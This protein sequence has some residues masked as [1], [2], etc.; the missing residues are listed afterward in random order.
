MELSGSAAA[1]EGL[2]ARLSHSLGLF[3]AA[4]CI[5]KLHAY[6]EGGRRAEGGS[7]QV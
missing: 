3:P 6:K 1:A 5:K 7:G 4:D 2:Q